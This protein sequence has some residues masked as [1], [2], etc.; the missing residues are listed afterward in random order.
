[1]QTF[2]YSPP[3][4]E[5]TNMLLY[6]RIVRSLQYQDIDIYNMKALWTRVLNKNYKVRLSWEKFN[7]LK[8]ICQTLQNLHND[9][10]KLL[11]N[12]NDPDHNIIVHACLLEIEES[13]NKTLEN[14]RTF[15]FSLE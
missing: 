7:Q 1:M 11:I 14:L 9:C 13:I 6:E 3:S 12:D 5:E 15:I 10:T 8:T 4:D 2:S